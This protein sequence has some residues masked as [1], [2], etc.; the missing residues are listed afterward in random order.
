MINASHITI[1]LSVLF[2]VDFYMHACTVFT[3]FLLTLS[4]YILKHSFQSKEQ[5]G[6][7]GP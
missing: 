3:G 5:N 7:S 1:Y 2:S 4:Y 6:S